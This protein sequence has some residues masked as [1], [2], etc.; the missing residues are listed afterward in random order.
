L[1]IG[2]VFEMRTLYWDVF[3]G[4]SGDMALASLIALGADPYIIK[5]QLYSLGLDTFDLEITLPLIQGIQATDVNVVLLNPGEHHHRRLAD[6]EKMLEKGELPAQ[7][8]TSSVQVFRSLAAAEAKIHG[9]TPDE[10]HFHEVGAVDSL[11][12]IIGTCLAIEKLAIEE[13]CVSLLPWSRGF[14]QCAHGILP[15]P[16]PATLEL[17]PGFEFAE[18]G[19]TGELVTPT[20]AALLA[21]LSKQRAFP[22]MKILKTGYGAGKNNYGLPNLL[23][24][25]L[26]QVS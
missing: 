13:I 8:R 6:I 4:I 23:R 20:A 26:G 5:E 17:L 21:T 22:K 14:V 3:A 9:I 24:S 11:V 2:E 15:V 18:S 10:V 1:K 25:V 12:D 7:A 16:A 19:V